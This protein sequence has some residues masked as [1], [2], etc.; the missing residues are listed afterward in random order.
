MMLA[1]TWLDIWMINN[2]TAIERMIIVCVFMFNRRLLG[3]E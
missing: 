2:G 1:R 3:L